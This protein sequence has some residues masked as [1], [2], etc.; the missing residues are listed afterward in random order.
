MASNHIIVVL[1]RSEVENYI[2]VIELE[3]IPEEGEEL[4]CYHCVYIS[5]NFIKEDGVYKGE[6]AV[7]LEPDPYE[8]Y[9][10]DLV[11]YD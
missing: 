3:M 6:D 10:K 11:L 4:G 8:E 2:E 7:G 5:L 1:V 9:I